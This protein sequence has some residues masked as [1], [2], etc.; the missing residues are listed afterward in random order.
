MSRTSRQSEEADFPLT[1]LEAQ[2]FTYVN[3][4][5]LA[6]ARELRQPQTPAERKIWARVRA[7]QL[8]LP[9]RRQHPIWR[10]IVDLYC[11]SVRLI[12]EV[13]GDTH[14]EPEQ[15]EYDAARTEWLEG[16]GYRVIRFTNREVRENLEVVLASIAR[17]CHTAKK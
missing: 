2:H 17:G 10:F 7:S 16:R 3:P 11:A 12:V 1:D 15:V 13:D 8:G 14:A 9:F 6:H 4:I 5:I